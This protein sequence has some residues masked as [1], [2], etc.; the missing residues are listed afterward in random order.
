MRG[1]TGVIKFDHEGFRSNFEL[2][3]VELNKDGLKKIGTWNS[4]EG[5]NFTRGYSEVLTQIVES[6]QNRT[7]VVTTILV[8]QNINVSRC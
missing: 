8:S 6:L 1:L 5:I 7:F 4:T 2:D 3:V